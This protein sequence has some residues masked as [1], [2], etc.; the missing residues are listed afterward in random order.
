M[1]MLSVV[2]SA[3]ILAITL[4]SAYGKTIIK[5]EG[6]VSGGADSDVMIAVQAHLTGPTLYERENATF[7][8]HASFAPLGPDP[9]H[10][11]FV[12][13]LEACRL[14]V[15]GV[16]SRKNDALVFK[17]TVKSSANRLF[18]GT[19]WV[20]SIWAETNEAGYIGMTFLNP[21]G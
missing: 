17:G 1:K 10:V 4:S 7:E 5:V 6:V 8:G 12:E 2:L 21:E 16:W 20:F 14:S 15:E 13:P 9:A 18:V 3:S 19:T 11:G